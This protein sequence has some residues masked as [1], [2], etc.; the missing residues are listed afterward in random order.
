MGGQAAS[1]LL[2]LFIMS[3]SDISTVNFSVVLTEDFLCVSHS[4]K[5]LSFLVA[6]SAPPCELLALKLVA[7]GCTSDG[8]VE[9]AGDT[10][11]EL[12]ACHRIPAS[13]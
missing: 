8:S 12:P 7:L 9:R 2:C 3:T 6:I 5:Y 1:S 13:S 11:A 10:R 4:C